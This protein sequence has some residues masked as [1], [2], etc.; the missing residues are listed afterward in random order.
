MSFTRNLRNPAQGILIFRCWKSL[1]PCL[2]CLSCS[3]GHLV[4]AAAGKAI[5]GIPP[6][7]LRHECLP[8]SC[9][10]CYPSLHFDTEDQS[11]GLSFL[12]GSGLLSCSMSWLISTLSFPDALALG[13]VGA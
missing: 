8:C 1:G 6:K 4:Q 9:A 13:T 5:L 2:T 12:S 11:C 10:S 3:L 7:N